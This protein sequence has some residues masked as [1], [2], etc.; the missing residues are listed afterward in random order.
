METRD[1]SEEQGLNAPEEQTLN[2]EAAAAESVS[3][4]EAAAPAEEA[5]QEPAAEPEPAAEVAPV[6][7]AEVA[8]DEPEAV[9]EEAVTEAIEAEVAEEETV[10]QVITKE[11]L[12]QRAEELLQKDAADIQ[13]DSITRLLHLFA[14]IKKIEDEQARTAWAEA[15]ND[16]EAY[17][18]VADADEEKF[19]ALINDIREKKNAWAAQQEEERQANLKAKNEIVAQIIALA[20]DTDNVNR[21]FPLYR[22][23]QDRF[24]AIGA[25]PPTD[26]T[27]VW[28]RFQDA[29]ERYSDNLKINKELRDYDFKKN[30][31]AKILLIEEADKLAQE[32]DVIV[33]FRRLQ[34]LHEKWRQIGPVA[35]ELREEIWQKF[36]DASAVVNKKYQAFFE[37]R[38]AREAESEAA[39]TKI[40]E[41]IEAL[42]YSGLSSFNA[43][44][45]MTK[46]II[47]MQ[48]EWKKLGYASRKA[49]N[50]LFA[51]FR[52]RCDAFFAAKAEYFKV[53]KA[54]YA[55]NLLKK[56][57]LAERAE[58]LKESREWRKA[59]DEFVAMQKE[60]KAIGPVPKKHSDSI[61]KR[62]L[63][64]CDY[65]FAH[66]KEA[67]SSQRSTEQANLAAKREI[68][69]AL[70]KID[71]TQDDAIDK[72][73]ELQ[74]KWQEIGHVPFRDKDKINE[75]YRNAINALRKSL[76][77]RGNRE[78]MDRYE[79]N[80]KDIEGD[81]GKLNRERERL[82]RS[83]E[84]RRIEIRTYENNLG[85]LSSKSKSGEAMVNEFRRK[86]ERLKEDIAQIEEKIRLI[87]S[88]Y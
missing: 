38:K 67:T 23:L 51:R 6:E 2:Q 35:K 63:A 48:A 44:E 32:P 16:P 4:P 70:G 62:F 34:D 46:Q 87:D 20:E 50:A 77:I 45:E 52:E 61:W 19:N 53:V 29:R 81:T 56:E 83:L 74:D 78:R 76:N 68:I 75:A 47:A 11:F 79:S 88:K 24:N 58:A 21:T 65:F 85:F 60:W 69:E 59:T 84:S 72:L 9:A 33:A 1:L 27:D 71:S 40:C 66:K 42:D 82:A 55:A 36:K 73:H 64:A 8:A 26:E 14:N 39:K 18:P 25:V 80:I 28:K 22:E 3:T 15:G 31:D 37:E 54:E 5:A 12:M 41:Q 7:A 13:R 57:A 86:I 49:N 17:Q 10:D 43:W 30:L